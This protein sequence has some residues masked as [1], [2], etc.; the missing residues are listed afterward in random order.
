MVKEVSG[1]TCFAVW[2]GWV[3]QCR[4]R[5][6]KLLRTQRRPH[7]M[8]RSYISPPAIVAFVA[9]GDGAVALY[10]ELSR[11]L[12]RRPLINASNGTVIRFPTALSR[13]LDNARSCTGAGLVVKLLRGL[14]GSVAQKHRDCFSVVQLCARF[15]AERLTS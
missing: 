5:R 13:Y 11:P 10:D 4:Q 3:T 6:G 9:V 2:L 14:L 7:T 8:L 15:H 12:R 1:R